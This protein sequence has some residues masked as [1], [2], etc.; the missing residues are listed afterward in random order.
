ME[1]RDPYFTA[2]AAL[3]LPVPLTALHFWRAWSHLP[4]QLATHF[5]ARWQPNGWSP[6]EEAVGFAFGVLGFVLLVVTAAC[7]LVR[8]RKPGQ[9]WPLLVLGAGAVGFI[10]WMLNQLV[11][12]NV[13]PG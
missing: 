5:D 8:A 9:A 4:L 1:R 7:A 2:L 6:R 11:S 13:L 10:S 12:R 3:W